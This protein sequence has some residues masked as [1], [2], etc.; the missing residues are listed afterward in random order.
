MVIYYSLTF[1][2]RYVFLFQLSRNLMDESVDHG[3]HFVVAHCK[4][5]TA[6]G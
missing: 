4:C 3:I 6:L 1:P 5:F 2:Q